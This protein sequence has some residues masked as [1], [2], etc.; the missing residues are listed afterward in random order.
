MIKVVKTPI[1]IRLL[2]GIVCLVII[3]VSAY[4]MIMAYKDGRYDMCALNVTNIIFIFSM[5]IKNSIR[6][7][8]ED[9]II[10]IDKKEE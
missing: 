1:L 4:C 8:I 10:N 5:F 2:L 9:D 7:M 3:F 6:Y